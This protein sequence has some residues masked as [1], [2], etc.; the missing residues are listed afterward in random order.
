MINGWGKFGPCPVLADL[1]RGYEYDVPHLSGLAQYSEG[2]HDDVNRFALLQFAQTPGRSVE[3]VG[4]AYAEEWLSL[5]GRDAEL[6]GQVIAGLGT[7]IV[8]DRIYVSPDY[9]ADNPQADDRLKILLD[10]RHR[11]PSLGENYRYWLLHYRAVCESFSTASG[12]LS[13]DVLAKEA[14]AARDALLRLEP[15]YGQ[16]LAKQPA[17]LRPGRSPW[18]WPRSFR[19]AWL[20]ENTFV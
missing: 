19:A 8:T 7:E 13:P 18:N 1:K 3:D 9:G 20:R 10:A 4:R 15:E 6:T 2:I 12:A 16:F 14:D 17:W 5:S 11:V